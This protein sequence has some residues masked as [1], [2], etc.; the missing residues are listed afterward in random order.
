MP[1]AGLRIGAEILNAA[2][3]TGKKR[4]KEAVIII[5]RR[6]SRRRI[7]NGNIGA[8]KRLEHFRHAGSIA[9]DGSFGKRT[10]QGQ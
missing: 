2:S 9:G 4:G 8:Q 10:S 6:S 7:T 1:V 5:F 3:C